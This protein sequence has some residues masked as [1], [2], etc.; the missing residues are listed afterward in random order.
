MGRRR[1]AY[2][3]RRSVCELPIP[4]WHDAPGSKIRMLDGVK[5]VGQLLYIGC[6]YRCGR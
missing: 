4:V 1:P 2:D 3:T 6:R 5:A